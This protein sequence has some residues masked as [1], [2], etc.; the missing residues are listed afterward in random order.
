MKK[1]F[2]IV[3]LLLLAG[4]VHATET[5]AEREAQDARERSPIK[6]L[7]LPCGSGAGFIILY[8]AEGRIVYRGGCTP[9]D[10]TQQLR[11]DAADVKQLYDARRSR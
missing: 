4:V 10:V 2:I 9:S 1:T 3:T 11:D 8:P 6:R 5:S 7:R